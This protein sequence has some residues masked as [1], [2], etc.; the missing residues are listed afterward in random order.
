MPRPKPFTNLTSALYANDRDQQVL[1][2]RTP[3]SRLESQ[4][5]AEGQYDD[6]DLHV[7]DGNEN[8]TVP[9]LSAEPNQDNNNNSTGRSKT[10]S[11]S[12]RQ[13]STAHFVD[14]PLILGILSAFFLFGLIVFSYKN[15]GR[16]Q[17]YVGAK[18]PKQ[19][20]VADA[21]VYSPPPIPPPEAPLHPSEYVTQ[22]RELNKGFMSHGDYWDKPL[23]DMGPGDDIEDEE[24]INDKYKL[25]E[26]GRTAICSKTITYMLDGEVGLLGDLALIAQ[27][28]ALAREVSSSCCFIAEEGGLMALQRNRT[29][30][31]DDTYWNRGK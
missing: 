16:L 14:V 4:D 19:S 11:K 18:A 21:A 17:E 13:R 1:T 22:C 24:D 28:A 20:P 8:Q 26:G 3:R 27:A 5:A 30:I 31:I 10:T 23:M 15:P 6:V 2:P 25:P 29:F 7:N 12:Q 9:L